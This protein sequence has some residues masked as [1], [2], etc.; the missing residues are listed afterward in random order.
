MLSRSAT[1]RSTCACTRMLSTALMGRASF[2]R[3]QVP[4]PLNEP[5]LDYRVESQER[6]ALR[7]AVDAAVKSCP[8][9]PCVIAG[10]QNSLTMFDDG[11]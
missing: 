6:N 3:S 1:S 11:D 8:E 10:T 9:I 2:G 7:A 4:K 5:L